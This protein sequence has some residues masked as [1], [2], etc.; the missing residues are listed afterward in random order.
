M[1]EM[2]RDKIKHTLTHDQQPDSP[3]GHCHA[4]PSATGS[5]SLQWENAATQ[6][7]DDRNID[8]YDGLTNCK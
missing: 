8:E 2:F 5:G 4:V 3:D 7:S 6:S 1:L